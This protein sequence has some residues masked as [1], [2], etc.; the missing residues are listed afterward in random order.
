MRTPNPAVRA[1]GRRVTLTDLPMV[2]FAMSCGHTG[3]DRAIQV[4]DWTFCDTCQDRVQV[5]AVLAA[6]SGTPVPTPGRARRRS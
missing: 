6:Q 2:V 5:G 1:R 3:K 4:G